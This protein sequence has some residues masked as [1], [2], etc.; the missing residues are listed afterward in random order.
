MQMKRAAPA[1]GG[2]RL[3]IEFGMKLGHVLI[4]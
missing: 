1:K 3:Y 2:R 4:F